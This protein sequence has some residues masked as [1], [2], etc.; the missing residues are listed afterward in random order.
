M[1]IDKVI[2]DPDAKCKILFVCGEVP[3]PPTNGVRIPTWNMIRVLAGICDLEVL[4]ISDEPES[5]MNACT[6]QL[7]LLNL[8][9]CHHLV[10][11]KSIN[12]AK[13]L[14]KF[15]LTRRPSFALDDPHPEVLR[16]LEDLIGRIKPNA[17]IF[18]A[19]HLGVFYRAVPKGILKVLSP[20]DSFSLALQDELAYGLHSNPVTRLYTYFNYKRTLMFESSLCREFNFCHF[21][22]Q[23]D[24][25][26]V[27]SIDPIINTFVAPNGVDSNYYKP[28]TQH[29][30]SSY[31]VVFVG[32]LIGGSL[33]YIN[34][35]I[36]H[37]WIPLKRRHPRMRLTLVSRRDP[38]VRLRSRYAQ[39][40]ISVLTGVDDLRPVYDSHGIVLS[41]VL[42]TC[43]ILNKVLEGMAMS[44][45]V[46]GYSPGFCGIPDAVNGEHF[47]GANS[48]SELTEEFEKIYRGLYNLE[49]IGTSARALVS[50]QYTWEDN[51]GKLYTHI[52]GRLKSAPRYSE[53]VT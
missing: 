15:V 43:G 10:I 7:N 53:W 36:A 40:D 23:V 31:D 47:I 41:P 25:S 24:A 22:S 37:V 18:D 35:F 21:V 20:N 17:V 5:D 29:Y 26:Y 4:I 32:G 39:H 14:A 8:S 1:G 42:K 44:R 48:P 30:P 49:K 13:K 46:V 38:G 28:L 52:V 9:D 34:M 11:G 45:A 19:E 33:R 2:V 3:F 27:K 16:E 51:I 6:R 12:K 50:S